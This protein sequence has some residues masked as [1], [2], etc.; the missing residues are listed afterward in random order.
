MKPEGLLPHSQVPTPV[1][2]LSQLDPVHTPTSHFLNIHLNPLNA[3]LN[4][5]CHLL[6]LLG[7]HHIL[8]VSNISVKSE[9]SRLTRQECVMCD[10]RYDV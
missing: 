5:V 6:A 10:G 9:R 1:P 3:D 4:P 8:H 2:I 7:A